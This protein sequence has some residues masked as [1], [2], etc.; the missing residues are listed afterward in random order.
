MNPKL[1]I[2]MDPIESIKSYKDS[3][4]AML[5]SA[6]DKNWQCF[7]FLQQNLFIED[8]KAFGR[9][10]KIS[11]IDNPDD[12]FV[13]AEENLFD[14]SDFDLILMRK[15]PPFDMSYVYT[16]YV[17]DI[18]QNSGVLIVNNPKALRNYNEKVA[19]SLFPQCTTPNLISSDRQQLLGFIDKYKD[20]I[21]KPLDGMGGASIFRI[22]LNDPNKSVI[23]ESLTEN[24]SKKIMAQVF[25]PEIS[26]GDKRIL[27]INGKPVPF[28][29]A[30]IPAKGETRG[31]LAAGG[32]GIVQ[33][34]SERDYWICQQ[35]SSFLIENGIYFAGIDVIGDYL[36]EINIT[37]PTCIREIDR[38]E[39]TQIA[40]L[41]FEEIEKSLNL[42]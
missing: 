15:D 32:T 17:L 2:I 26:K 16:T 31:N 9:G 20:V 6:Q 1:A 22:S 3:S 8:G 36:T 12:Y 19:I 33:P 41:L 21:V 35:L 27:I 7:Y 10:Q 38:E 5:L 4:F 29:L 40:H 34:L 37:S 11:V 23:L 25:I 13:L 18:A 39:N 30:R 14:L 42:K 24:F 28:S